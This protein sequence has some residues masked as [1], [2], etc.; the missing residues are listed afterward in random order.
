M[1]NALRKLLRKA[2]DFFGSKNKQPL[3]GRTFVRNQGCWNCVSGVF[4]GPILEKAKMTTGMRDVKI[5]MRE[6]KTVEQTAAIIAMRDVKLTERGAGVCLRGAPHGGDF[7]SPK[8]LCSRWVGR[9]GVNK[10][11]GGVDDLPEELADKLGDKD[12]TRTPGEV[13]TAKKIEVV[14]ASGVPKS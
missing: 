5:M 7:V 13:A 6:G 1:S 9:V 4:D 14:D 2:K 12:D 10:F 8:L 11:T 3:P